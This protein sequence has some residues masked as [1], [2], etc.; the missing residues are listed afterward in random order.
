MPPPMMAED[1]SD[2]ATRGI[3]P[4]AASTG[5]GSELADDATGEL[6]GGVGGVPG[7]GT[8][9]ACSPHLE[10]MD[11]EIGLKVDLSSTCRFCLTSEKLTSID[12]QGQVDG[13]VSRVVAHVVK[14][15]FPHR[16]HSQQA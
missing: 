12:Q 7:A 15:F 4:S 13:K 3:A 8:L 14:V 6:S 11:G 16:S 10:E 5:A 9:H 2:A 1:F